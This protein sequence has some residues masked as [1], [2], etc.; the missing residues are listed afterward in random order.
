M[1]SLRILRPMR[2]TFVLLCLLILAVGCAQGP[3]L[4][5][6]AVILA[7]DVLALQFAPDGLT[8]AM[9]SNDKSLRLIDVDSGVER[10]NLPGHEKGVWALAYSPDNKM[11]ASAASDGTVRIWN[12]D[13][14]RLLQVLKPGGYSV[15]FR[16]DSKRLAVG[17]D[18]K[19][20]IYNTENWTLFKEWA[21][22]DGNVFTVAFSEDGK[23]LASGTSKGL[24]VWDADAG[25]QMSAHV[26]NNQSVRAIC[27][28]TEEELA[29]YYQGYGVVLLRARDGS[30]RAS[31]PENGTVAF[32]GNGKRAIVASASLSTLLK[33]TEAWK[34]LGS[35]KLP[36]GTVNAVTVSTDGKLA[37]VAGIRDVTVLKLP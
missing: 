35:I 9:G 20:R 28:P 37:A 10:A 11:L 5:K 2:K 18:Y 17:S 3:S 33:D 22:P 32:S 6:G 30:A 34:D 4:K 16:P 13:Q 19:I 29:A 15:A 21:E 25:T 24:K 8:L 14:K 23:K 12:P 36:L 31:H 1:P 7:S 27:F 26:E